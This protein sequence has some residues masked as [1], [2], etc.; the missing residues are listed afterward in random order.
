MAQVTRRMRDGVLE[1]DVRPASRIEFRRPVRQR[2][3]LHAR[4]QIAA[5]PAA[6][7]DVQQYC[8]LAFLGQ[9]QNRGG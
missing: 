1:E 2:L 6:E 7:R 4:K 5:T 3:I 9:R 8:D